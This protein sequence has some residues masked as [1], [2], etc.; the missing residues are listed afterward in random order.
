M[1]AY[2]L[3]FFKHLYEYACGISTSEIRRQTCGVKESTMTK[4]AKGKEIYAGLDRPRLRPPEFL[5]HRM[6]LA[7]LSALHL[8]HQGNT[9]GSHFC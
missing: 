1:I 8:Y 4:K 7:R 2:F 6:K 3:M 5:D 9:S